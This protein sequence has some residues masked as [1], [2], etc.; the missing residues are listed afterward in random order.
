VARREWPLVVFTILGQTA[1]GAFWLA[2]MPLAFRGRSGIGTGGVSLGFA[3]YGGITILLGLAAAASFLHLARPWRAVLA[4]SNLRRSWLSREILGEIV[5]WFLTANLAFLEWITPGCAS[6]S[7]VLRAAVLAAGLAGFAFLYGMARLYMLDTV[8]AWRGLHTPASFFVSAFLLG[9]LG[10]AVYLDWLAGRGPGN[11]GPSFRFLPPVAL[12]A[13]VAGMA[14]TVLLAPRF[15]VFGSKVQTPRMPAA[16][17]LK[18][19]YAIRGLLLAGAGAAVLL[20]W[21]RLDAE[22][23]AGPRILLWAAAAAGLAAEAFG[24]FLFYALYGRVGV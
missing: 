3:V 16:R 1:V 21:I 8:P 4:L 2:G 24:R 19:L 12:A 22:P 23:P 11:A 20:D 15:G 18:A 6:R 17:G 9:G 7:L 5:F 13:A 10:A 14:V